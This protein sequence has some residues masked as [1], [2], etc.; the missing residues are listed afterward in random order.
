[1][2]DKHIRVVISVLRPDTTRGLDMDWWDREYDL[3]R[4]QFFR[5]EDIRRVQLHTILG[6]QLD[7]SFPALNQL[8]VDDTG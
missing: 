7:L 2:G 1:M 3:I 5:R 6:S 4:T 8:G